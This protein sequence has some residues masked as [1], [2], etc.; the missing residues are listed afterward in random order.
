MGIRG[1]EI[2]VMNEESPYVVGY[3][4]KMDSANLDRENGILFMRSPNLRLMKERIIFNNPLL[5]Y[6]IIRQ[7]S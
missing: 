1:G 5:P 4:Y 7:N 3:K 6:K 2:E